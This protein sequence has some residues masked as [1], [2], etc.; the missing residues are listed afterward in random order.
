MKHRISMLWPD[1]LKKA[2]TFSYD[3]GVMQDLKLISLFRLYGLKATFNLNS[4]FFGQI[5][6][7][8]SKGR[9]IDHSHVSEEDIS[10][11]YSGFEVAVHTAHHPHLPQLSSVNA[12]EEIISDRIAMEKLVKTPVRGMAYPFGTVNESVKNI[13]KTCGIV[14][15]RGTGVTGDYSLPMD[16]YDWSCSCHHNDL[17]PLIDP[18]LEDD[19][20]LMLLSVWGHSYEFDINASWNVI[21]SQLERLGGNDDV[22]YATNIEIFD[23]IAAYN[24]LLWTAEG[25]VVINP[26]HQPIFIECDGE[27]VCIE[28]GARVT[29]G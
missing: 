14:Y 26:S 27:T 8:N 12:V 13:V 5:D 1:G 20:R 24:A 7:F 10:S 15:S 28:G 25:D 6:G 11:V 23:Y 9:E 29:L 22:W 19:R 16:A 18:F 17:E 21:E 3:D 2:L 4:A